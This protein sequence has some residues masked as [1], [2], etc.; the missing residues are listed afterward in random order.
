MQKKMKELNPRMKQ[1]E[2][3]INISK[4]EEI[5]QE[6]ADK[7]IELI[8]YPFQSERLKGLY[9]SDETDKY[10]ALSD[11][12]KTTKEKIC[13]LTEELSHDQLTY[14][15]ISDDPKAEKI[16]RFD[17]YDKLV[18]IKGIITAYEKGCRTLYE[19]SEEL[20]VTYD[21]LLECLTAYMNKYGISI[22][23]ENYIINFKPY[24]EIKIVDK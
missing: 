20:N 13:V 24:L 11:K 19:F 5:E 16:A 23:Y 7:G 17:C 18:G 6:I 22:N 15:N 14:G 8:T 21:F 12:V 9:L 3:T 2:K 1:K 4:L 10:I